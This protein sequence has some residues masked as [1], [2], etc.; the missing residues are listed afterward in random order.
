MEVKQFGHF[1]RKLRIRTVE[2]VQNKIP[3]PVYKKAFLNILLHGFSILVQ[4]FQKVQI[5]PQ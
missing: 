5:G 1:L 3:R 2:K 4:S